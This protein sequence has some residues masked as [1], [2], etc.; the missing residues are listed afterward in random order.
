[1]EFTKQPANYLSKVTFASFGSDFSKFSGHLPQSK[2][3]K[4]L[5]CNIRLKDSYRDFD[6]ADI[7]NIGPIVNSSRSVTYCGISPITTG[8]LQD[9]WPYLFS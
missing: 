4:L 2:A 8:I 5:D 1:M 6:A 7:F 3:S 9:N